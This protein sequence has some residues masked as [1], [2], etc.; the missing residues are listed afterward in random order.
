MEEVVWVEMQVLIVDAFSMSSV[1]RSS[2]DSFKRVVTQTLSGKWK[3]KHDIIVR[4]I[5][6]LEDYVCDWEH[7]VL[8]QSS[9]KRCAKFDKVDVI[10]IAGDMK[11]CPWDPLFTKAIT[12]LYMADRCQKPVVG[13]GAGAFAGIYCAATQGRACD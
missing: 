4:R 2:F 9:K 11:V 12:L 5:D 10:C 1:G 13:A 7:D 8:D 6:Q 3:E